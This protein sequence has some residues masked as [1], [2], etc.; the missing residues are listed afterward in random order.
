M[1]GESGSD[2]V[3]IV[4]PVGGA[5]AAGVADI[6]GVLTTMVEGARS[7]VE[8][9]PAGIVFWTT[10]A[11]A[12]RVLRE[13]RAAIT[14]LAA[15]G[16]RVDPH[17]VR[18]EAASPESEWRD[19]WKRHFGVTRVSRRLVI[20]PSWERFSP[21]PGDVVLEI[22]PGRAF[23]TGAHASTRLCLTELDQLAAG[24]SS[25][26]GSGRP[27]RRF[28]DLGTGSGILAVAAA[29]LWPESSGV[30]TDVDPM[31]VEVAAE[32]AQ[33]NDVV[34]QITCTER[35]IDAIEERFDLVTANI[36]AEVL[37]PLRATIADRVAGGGVVIL[38]GLLAE[39]APEVA[40]AYAALPHLE[41]VRVRTAAGD[42]TEWSSVLLRCS[43]PQGEG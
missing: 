31:A 23:G 28:L 8:V 14:M 21:G 12:G 9:R 5:E 1:S 26:P 32:T 22:D 16:A 19:A 30:A 34:E 35:P 10:R 27:V 43:Q 11:D 13:T 42:G 3:E 24:G 2:W 18:Q 39:E 7:G 15:H 38:S 4:V 17:A 33:R 25:L 37:R 40:E 29:K 41:I 6:A 20:V 36:V